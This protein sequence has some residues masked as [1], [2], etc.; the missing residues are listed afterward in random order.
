[1][2]FG[3]LTAVTQLVSQLQG[4]FVNLSGIGPKYFA[5]TAACQRLME[6]EE[7]CRPAA[8]EKCDIAP[9]DIRAIC[10][11]DLCFSYGREPVLQGG[12]FRLEMGSFAVVTGPSGIGKSTLLKLLLGI[13]PPGSGKLVLETGS[14]LVPITPGSRHLFAYVPQGNLL[15]S[16]TVRENLLLTNP[17]A[18]EEAIAQA[19]YISGM[20]S[21]LPQLPK[22]L[23]T[24]LGENA[25][26]L[27]EGQAQRLS[28]ARAVLSGAP[29]LLLDECT[30]ALDGETEALVLQRLRTLGR[31][32][33]AVTHRAAMLEIAD[34]RLEVDGGRIRAVTKE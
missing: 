30:S 34:S 4:P 10:A 20:D 16:G 24:E 21:Y 31:T 33:I 15:L 5:M 12:S 29:I 28:I 14:G 23:E 26:G 19:V 13:Y 18:T 8:A 32:C 27:S 3:D 1:M 9:E 6:L 17:E 22:G 7:K 11:E 25:L 2:T